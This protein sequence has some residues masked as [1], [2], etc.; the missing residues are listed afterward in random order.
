MWGTGSQSPPPLRRCRMSDTSLKWESNNYTLRR[1][2]TLGELRVIAGYAAGSN[3]FIELLVWID[4]L[5][6]PG[7][8]PAAPAETEAQS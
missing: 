8:P 1:P 7:D 5:P 6:R 4:K 2:W 3:S